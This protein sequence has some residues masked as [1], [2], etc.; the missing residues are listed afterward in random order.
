[1]NTPKSS[2]VANALALVGPAESAFTSRWRLSTLARV[3]EELHRLLNE[4]R[5]LYDTALLM[6]TDAEVKE[7]SEAMVRGW[8]AACA[9]LEQP[10]QD[11]DAYMTGTDLNT[12]TT[13]VIGDHRQSAARHQ[14][15]DGYSVVFVTPDEVAALFGS[16]TTLRTVKDLF[17][18]AEI[19]TPTRP[20]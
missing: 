13:V 20:R 6:G 16:F 10:L 1:M 14:V 17:P 11:D 9:A 15:K 7:Q 18:D 12:F 3:N 2:T 4:Q 8:R 19:I 5:E